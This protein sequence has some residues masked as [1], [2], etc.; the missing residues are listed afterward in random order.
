MDK[1]GDDQ[2]SLEVWTQRITQVNNTS[3]VVCLR[4]TVTASQR[5]LCCGVGRR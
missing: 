4:E 3:D 2:R 5:L 1:T